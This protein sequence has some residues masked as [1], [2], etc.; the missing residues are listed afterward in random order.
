MLVK[1]AANVLEILEFYAVY[2]KPAT[3]AEVS[4]HFGWP[5]SSTFNLL[6]TL[7]DRGFLY[8]P[9]ARGGFFPTSRW[10]AL[11]QEIAA[12]EPLPDVL[13]KL[14]HD[15]AQRTG[16]TVWIAAPSGQHAVFLEVIEASASIRYTA[17]AGN[18][19]PLYA[20]A[21][22]QALLC[23][24]TETQRNSIL[25]KTVF[26]RY[27]EGT[28][29]SIETVENSIRTSLH[30]GWFSS[31]SAYN[32]DLCGVA[33]PLKIDQR[34]LAVTVAGPLFRMKDRAE[35]MAD[36]LNQLIEMYLSQRTPG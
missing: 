13:L 19:V 8:E 11:S 14:L 35:E 31:A 16:E 29:M 32:P 9:R 4:Q 10:L 1:Q 24:M 21:T 36:H 27:G 22:G 23:Q 2:K 7:V 15:L 26:E 5:R 20:T 25:R 17:K 28:P 12:A 33:V 30:R 3:L 6:S 18:R 34:I